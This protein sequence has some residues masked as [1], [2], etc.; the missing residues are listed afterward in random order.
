MDGPG[1][2]A[3]QYTFLTFDLGEL[4]LE[5]YAIIVRTRQCVAKEYRLLSRNRDHRISL[6][7]E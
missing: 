5:R 3:H 1:R 2:G 6:H 4:L 7:D